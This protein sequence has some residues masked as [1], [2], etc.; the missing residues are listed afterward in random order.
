MKPTY[1]FL[2]SFLINIFSSPLWSAEIWTINKDHSELQF[3][4]P[5]MSITDIS[6]RFSDLRGEAEIENDIVKNINVVVDFKS[7]YTGNKI[8]DGHLK[9]PDFINVKKNPY[10]IFKSSTSLQLN[11]SEQ[12][13]RGKLE[14]NGI[15]KDIVFK[16]KLSSLNRDTWNYENRF[17]WFNGEID[18]RDFNITWDK[19]IQDNKYLVG[20]KIKLFGQIQLQ[21]QGEKTP[22]HKFMIPDTK[23]TRSKDK[24]N[25]GELDRKD[26][27][28]SFK[29]NQQDITTTNSEVAAVKKEE[30]TKALPLH[31]DS[32]SFWW[33]SSFLFIGLCAFSFVIGISFWIKMNF[34]KIFKSSYR[35]LGSIGILSDLIALAII[36]IFAM[37]IWTLGWGQ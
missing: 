30:M 21:P 26:F 7:I 29:L 5:Y 10:V 27:E 37:C 17:V 3:K 4:I 9:S 16:V 1:I 35:E 32:K 2:L 20:E 8:R 12:P 19:T 13:L 11:E 15:T 14:I 34:S 6:G 24:V 22:T 31:S 18:R 25:R 36:T 23:F 33:W 28:E